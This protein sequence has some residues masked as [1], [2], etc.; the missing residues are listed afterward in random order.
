MGDCEILKIK[1]KGR[2]WE[3]SV[4][5]LKGKIGQPKKEKGESKH[6]DKGEYSFVKEVDKRIKG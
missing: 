6:K 3:G 4:I 2:L 5:G 1:R